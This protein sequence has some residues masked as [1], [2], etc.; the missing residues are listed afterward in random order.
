MSSNANVNT[1]VFDWGGTLMESDRRSGGPMA[2]WPEV[3]AVDGIKDALERLAGIYPMVIASNAA[4][5]NAAQVLAALER[6]E[7][8]SFFQTA[9]TS[10]ELR[11]AK[12]DLAF[13][14]AIE[15]RLGKQPEQLC[16]VGDDLWADMHGAHNAGWNAIWFNRRK[17]A[18]GGLMPP[19]DAEI[20]HMDDLP[21]AV[22]GLGLPSQEE[23]LTWL[24]E[25]GAS[26]NLFQHVQ[27]VAAAAYRLAGW[28]RSAGQA[29]NP[30][31]AQRGGLLHDLAKISARQINSRASH[32]EVA[33]SL[34]RGRRQAA[35]AEIARRHM[36]FSLTEPEDRPTRW[37]EKLVY[38]SDKLVESGRLVSPEERLAALSLRYPASAA[39][40]E[41]MQS[42]LLALQAEIARAA[43]IPASELL[44]KLKAALYKN[45]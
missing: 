28:L 5:S 31:L 37:E 9:F 20:I 27:M 35:L 8:Q 24:A 26:F 11:A 41:A 42:P 30:I 14:R 22:A 17:T 39:R 7:L 3:K 2:Q 13:F 40:I 15:A 32:G 19:H 21:E 18:C 36:L 34:L 1:L 6:V 29:V 25:Q 45:D 43:G 33:A 4:D 44:S 38:F 12:P 16:M 10:Y 23:C